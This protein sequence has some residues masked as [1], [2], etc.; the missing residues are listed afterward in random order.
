MFVMP[1][2]T[3]FYNINTI[4]RKGNSIFSGCFIALKYSIILVQ[5]I[6]AGGKQKY[7]D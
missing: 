4:Y 1:I 3:S 7:A 5:L 2:N 6:A